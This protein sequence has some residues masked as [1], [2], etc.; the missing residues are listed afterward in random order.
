MLTEFLMDSVT[1]FEDMQWEQCSGSFLPTLQDVYAPTEPITF[2][3]EH[4]CLFVPFHAGILSFT[5]L[6]ECM[7]LHVDII[8]VVVSFL[9]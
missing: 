2:K 7:L 6:Y 1:N 3:K 8:L 4:L 5:G 9:H